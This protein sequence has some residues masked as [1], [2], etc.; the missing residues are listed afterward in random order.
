M[1]T[2]T[3][4]VREPHFSNIENGKKIVKVDFENTVSML[5]KKAIMYCGS[6]EMMKK[7]PC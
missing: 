7:N 2:H 1:E 5:S 3:K 6:M 4:N